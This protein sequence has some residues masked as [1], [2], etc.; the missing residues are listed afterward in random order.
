MRTAMCALLL[1][2][3]VALP[4]QTRSEP[5][6]VFSFSLGLTTGKDLWSIPRQ[7]LSVPG[8]AAFDTASIDRSLRPG[9]TAT[10]SAALYTSPSFAWTAEIGYYGLGTEQRCEGPAVYQ[11]D[12]EDTNEQVCTSASGTR[13]ATSIVGLQAGGIYRFMPAKRVTPYVRA[14]AGVG[15]IGNSFVTTTGCFQTVCGYPLI[16]PDK[17]ASV[18]WISTLTGGISVNVAQAYR[19]RMEFRDVIASVPTVTGVAVFGTGSHI[20]PTTRRVVH[21]PTFL[22]GVDLVFERRHTRRY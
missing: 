22:F 13:R 12:P 1:L 4:A 5:N 21:V 7:P 3:P 8:S 2:A 9:L 14:T 11:P 10:L 15:M 6:L 18:T 17:G 19:V 20:A 16:E